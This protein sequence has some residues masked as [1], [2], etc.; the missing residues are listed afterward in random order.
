[1]VFY[2]SGTGNSRFA[3]ER[4]AEAIGQKAEDVTAYKKSGE[5]PVF[6]EGGAYLFSCPCYMSTPARSM[7]EFIESATFPQGVKAYFLI[8]CAA[9]LGASSRVC[10]E[11]CE[12]NGM[13]YMGASQVVMP[14]N[15][16]AL[17]SMKDKETNGRIVNEALPVI[18]HIAETIK[19]GGKL[20][21]KKVGSAEYAITKWVRDLYYK[22]FM[23]TKKFLATDACVS[24]GLCAGI[25]PMS[26]IS[27]T[28]GKPVWDK[29]CT[30]CMACIN[31]CPK[32]AIEY[33][34]GS[35][36]K[37]RYKGPESTLK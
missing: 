13:E 34:K 15:Y 16:I 4:I 9:S 8:T 32:D 35:V 3:A 14:Q 17:F 33:G 5:S 11:L 26:N 25:C 31:R 24:C 19:S 30:H 37:I 10:R 18:D 21:D 20:D 1:M 6:T 7:T 2:F 12:K 22:D 27:M 23:K 36:G 29:N 28:D